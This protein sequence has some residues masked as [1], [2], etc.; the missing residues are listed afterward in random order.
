MDIKAHVAS[1]TYDK[2]YQDIELIDHVGYARSFMTWDNIK[3]LVDWKGKYVTDIGSFHGYFCLKAL[4]A[5]ASHVAG[6]EKNLDA[7]NTAQLIVNEM[8]LMNSPIKFFN[9]DANEVIIQCDILL[10]LNVFHHISNQDEFLQSILAE[11]V[12]FEI[13]KEDLPKIE[14]YCRILVNKPSHRPSA[15]TGDTPNRLVLVATMKEPIEATLA[16]IT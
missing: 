4:Q 3:D 5:G 13:D 14:K 8:G 16:N 2:F 15:Y 7:M 1:R 9:A 10:C 11:I 6:V 12:I